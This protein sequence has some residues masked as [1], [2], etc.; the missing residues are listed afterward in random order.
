MIEYINVRDQESARTAIDV[1]D[2]AIGQVSTFRSYVGALHNRLTSAFN[3]TNSRQRNQQNALGRI[4]D[5]DIAEEM[6]NVSKRQILQMSAQKVLVAANRSK[7]N[8]L[9]LL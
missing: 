6:L 5:A 7:L 4:L 8:L 3:E 2:I 9:K 1:I